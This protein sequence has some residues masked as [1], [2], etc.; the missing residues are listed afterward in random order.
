MAPKKDFSFVIIGLVLL[1][2][3]AGVI[4]LEMRG[5]RTGGNFELA[6]AEGPWEFKD[7]AKELNLL[8]MGYSKCPD[9]CPLVLA[10][11]SQSFHA[12]SEAEVSKTSLIFVS[13][14]FEHDTP[15]DV[16]TYA[17]QFYKS[18]IGLT[19]S[20]QQIDSVS[21]LFNAAYVKENQPDSYLGYSIAHA[22]RIYFL[23]NKG[24]I[25]DKLQSPRNSNEILS[26]IRELL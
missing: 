19:G 6:S 7:H 21:H 12:L 10:H 18:F 23:N 24:S 11:A 4:F 2:V 16:A 22:D 5:P 20:Q 15:T 1:S 8:Y 14:D 13:V 26:K 25:L 17:A 9:V 3:L